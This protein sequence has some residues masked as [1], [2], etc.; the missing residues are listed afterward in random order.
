MEP[1]YAPEGCWSGDPTRCPGTEAR[2]IVSAYGP[3]WYDAV[4]LATG[5]TTGGRTIRDAVN[6]G[7][8]GKGED[9]RLVLTPRG[10]EIQGRIR[11]AYK[12]GDMKF[13]IGGQVHY[14]GDLHDE[15]CDGNGEVT[16]V[17]DDP[18]GDQIVTVEFDCGL[19]QSHP[20]TNLEMRTP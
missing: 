8:V 3:I 14:P 13:Q 20:G 18:S 1:W 6:H 15:E 16:A 11:L 4:I 17:E 9:G 5:R 12:E 19:T 7:W 2:G 10:Q